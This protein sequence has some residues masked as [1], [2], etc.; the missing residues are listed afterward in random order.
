M[1]LFMFYSDIPYVIWKDSF[2]T[3]YTDKNSTGTEDSEKERRI[4]AVSL[5]KDMVRWEDRQ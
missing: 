2:A 5:A 1:F 3:P 4:L